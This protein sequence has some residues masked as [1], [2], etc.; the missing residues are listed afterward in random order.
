MKM[1]GVIYPTNERRAFKMKRIIC[2]VL[3]ICALICSLTSCAVVEGIFL[4]LL[5]SGTSEA[6]GKVEEMVTALSEGRAD[7]AL[8]YM[9]PAAQADASS[10]INTMIEY[11][12]GRSIESMQQTG[13]YTNSTITTLGTIVKEQIT[14][15]VVFTD[16]TAIGIDAIYTTNF[17]G[18]GFSKFLITMGSIPGDGIENGPS[19]AEII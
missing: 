16:G 18:Q 1:R 14:Y 9:H 13:Y 17:E 4:G 12:N 2:L 6:A 8:L 11:I 5:V 15:N 10:G 3:V 19:D 7:D